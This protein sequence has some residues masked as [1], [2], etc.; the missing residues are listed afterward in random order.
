MKVALA[1]INI[2]W[3]NPKEN[4]IKCEKFIKKASEKNADLIIF[5][6]MA[7]TGFTMNI[8]SLNLKEQFILDWIK[9][10]AFENNIN[11]VIYQFDKGRYSWGINVTKQ[12]AVI[13]NS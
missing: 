3:E 1:Q 2:A 8:K 6:E 12:T 9:S 4:L 13:N 5:P 11:I 10:K 7:L